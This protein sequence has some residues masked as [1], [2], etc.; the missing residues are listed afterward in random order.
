LDGDQ[1]FR[2]FAEFILRNN[3]RAALLGNV[4]RWGALIILILSILLS[5]IIFPGF[6]FG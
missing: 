3:K 2:L 5:F 1:L 6:T 4:I